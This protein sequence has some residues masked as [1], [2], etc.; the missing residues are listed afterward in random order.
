MDRPKL[1]DKQIADNVRHYL[2]HEKDL[3][4]DHGDSEFI[5][6]CH[7]GAQ[8]HRSVILILEDILGKF[9]R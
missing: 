5:E 4:A 6:E 8:F 3:L 2:E 9:M 7:T 1:T